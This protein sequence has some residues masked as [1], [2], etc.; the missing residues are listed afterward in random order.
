MMP[1]L[2]PPVRV[3][4]DRKIYTP[5]PPPSV[6]GWMPSLRSVHVE[7]GLHRL[8]LIEQFAGLRWR[9]LAWPWEDLAD[10]GLSRGRLLVV[11]AD[12]RPL[13][14]FVA[15]DPG[16]LGWLVGEI[17][18][19]VARHLLSDL[20]DGARRSQVRSLARHARSSAVG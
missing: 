13:V 19:R 11:R 6:F 18:S 4:L 15:G 5:D 8:V 14:T 12:G 10:A 1:S 9:R 7:I 2:Q 3:L 16:Q 20:E 17:K